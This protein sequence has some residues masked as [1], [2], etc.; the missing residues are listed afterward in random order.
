[1]F[2]PSYV[3]VKCSNIHSCII[4]E[5]V[6]RCRKY[7]TCNAYVI[8]S[9]DCSKNFSS[10]KWHHFL[11]WHVAQ[12]D[13][14][15]VVHNLESSYLWQ[16]LSN[17]SLWQHEK[18]SFFGILLIKLF[19]T[20]DYLFI[21]CRHGKLLRVLTWQANVINKVCLCSQ[22]FFIETKTATNS[23]RTFWANPFKYDNSALV[24]L[25]ISC[26]LHLLFD[27]I[28]I[29]SLLLHNVQASLK[30][31][32]IRLSWYRAYELVCMCDCM[33]SIFPWMSEGSITRSS[34]LKLQYRPIRFL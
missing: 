25:V 17:S 34:C 4:S 14:K 9:A 11:V 5:L 27:D 21:L 16:S 2:H 33:S 8:L 1:M 29:S 18:R 15:M 20:F 31:G 22:L 19:N 13:P 32:W 7:Y 10:F 26:H 6:K 3:I 12:D 23:K 24:P 30:S 28:A